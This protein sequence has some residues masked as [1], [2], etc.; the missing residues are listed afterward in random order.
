MDYKKID[1]DTMAVSR[2]TKDFEKGTNNIYETTAILAIRAEQIAQ[3]LKE[4]FE[5]KVA[6]F[7]NVNDSLEEIYENREQIEVARYYERLPKPTLLATWEYLNDKIY[8]RNPIKE[9]SE[10]HF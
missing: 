4:E 1:A 8:F 2:N 6:E 5:E 7:Q 9:E 3:A 10:D